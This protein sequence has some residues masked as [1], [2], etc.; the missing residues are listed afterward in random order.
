MVVVIVR[1]DSLALLATGETD[2]GATVIAGAGRSLTVFVL[3]VE[4]LAVAETEGVVV[5][6]LVTAILAGVTVGVVRSMV[7][8]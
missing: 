5:A 2:E 7:P 4:E 3:R 1:D 6:G 8:V